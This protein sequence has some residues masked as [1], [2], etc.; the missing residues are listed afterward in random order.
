MMAMLA[1]RATVSMTLFTPVPSGCRA[2]RDAV[3]GEG[4]PAVGEVAGVD[5]GGP[6]EEQGDHHAGDHGQHRPGGSG[7]RPEEPRP[8]VSRG[9]GSS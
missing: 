9:P 2:R 6:V 1:S 3:G 4:P 7:V 8:A 5:L